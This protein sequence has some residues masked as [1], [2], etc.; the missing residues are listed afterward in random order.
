MCRGV[1]TILSY[2]VNLMGDLD[3]FDVIGTMGVFGYV[4]AYLALQ[5][6]LLKGDGYIFPSINLAASLAVMVSLTRDFNPFS[7][8]IEICWS[9]ISI[10][11]IARI[12]LVSRF[13]SLSEEEAEVA[14]RI[15]PSLKKD[16][17]KKLLKLGQF[18]DAE[19]GRVL[20]KQGEPVVEIAMIMNGMCAIESGGAHIASISIG[21]LVGELTL[22][23]GGPATATV[24]TVV[25][26]R[27]F[28]I[29]RTALLKF[30]QQ[31]PE[32]MADMERSIAGDLRLK[33]TDTSTRLSTIIESR[34]TLSS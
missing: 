16:R 5:L 13:I 34:S 30:L 17:A 11:G 3:F 31:N 10:I 7:V 12:Y 28:L 33:L 27:L 18:V 15:V 32:A 25:P 2:I 29:N 26:S 4:G 24:R 14:R 23:T 21:A 22:S 9:I 19:E 1:N 20:T 6:G 8:T